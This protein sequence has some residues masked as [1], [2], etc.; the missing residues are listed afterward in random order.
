M[1]L[2]FLCAY[3][4]LTAVSLPLALLPPSLE[5]ATPFSPRPNAEIDLGLRSAANGEEVDQESVEWAKSTERLR[6][7]LPGASRTRIVDLSAE[8]LH[9][10]APFRQLYLLIWGPGVR[11]GLE[12]RDP[13]SGEETGQLCKVAP[14]FVAR[15]R[16]T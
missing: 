5:E 12:C 1:S 10:E 9:V 3:L 4:I 11:Q 2:R 14:L 16:P 13:R 7:G 15:A 6:P 8:V